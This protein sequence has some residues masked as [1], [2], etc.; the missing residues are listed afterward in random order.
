MNELDKVLQSRGSS[1]GDFRA[2]AE[3]AQ[4]LKSMI[5][6]ESMNP[7]QKEVI[8]LICTKLARLSEGDCNNRDSWLD[9]AGYAQ[10][11]VVYVDK[12]AVSAKG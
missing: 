9:I 10:L 7:A 4:L 5:K 1:Y 3:K 2:M 12:A 6:S 8:D 11:A